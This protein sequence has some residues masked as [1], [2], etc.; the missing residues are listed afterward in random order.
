[1]EEPSISNT[2]S[3]SGLFCSSKVRYI[4]D[5]FQEHENNGSLNYGH[6]V[7]HANKKNGGIKVIQKEEMS[8]HK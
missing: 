1:M 3:L 6:E 8:M 2:L 4:N 7:I 5:S